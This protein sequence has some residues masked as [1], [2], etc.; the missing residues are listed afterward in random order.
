MRFD[1]VVLG[2][3][4][5]QGKIVT[6]DLLENGYSV[7]MCGRDKSRIL[8]LLKRYKKT[9]FEYV[10]MRDIEHV[11]KIIKNSKAEVVVN[12]IEGDWNLNAMKACIKAKASVLDLGSEIWMTKKQ[13]EYDSLLKKK[14]ITSITGCGS[15]PGVGNVMLRYAAEK[16]DKIDTVEVG[17]AWD[18]NMKVFVVPFSM[19]SILEEFTSSA[20]YLHNHKMVTIRPTDSIVKAYHRGIGREKEF[21]CGHH[22]ETYTFCR[23]CRNKG[24]KNIEF[25]AGFPEHSMQV[26]QT[27][28]DLGFAKKKKISIKGVEMWPDEFL[29]ALLRRLKYPKGYTE[30]EN[31]WV[32][33]K[34]SNGNR[35]K[36][37]ILMECIVPPLKGWEDA[38][39][40]ID[41][42]MPAS[43]IAQMVK[44]KIINEKGSFSPEAVVPPE[45]F[46]KELRKRKMIVYE[47]GKVIN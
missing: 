9:G 16:F 1:F 7:L 27:L 15:V 22:P 41:T 18:S 26:V 13:I 32:L 11:A 8:H 38:G 12:C 19:E 3:T 10:E 31:L 24:V 42:G 46:F 39:C 20:P 43:I 47:N 2:A 29:T 21:L 4:G 44:K 37:E 34:G 33:I 36:K 14:G 45:P 6:R 23:F 25:Y 35:K 5:M 30:T 17:F 28:V 40:N